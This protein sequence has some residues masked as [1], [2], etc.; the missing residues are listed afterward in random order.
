ML[1]RF[2]PFQLD[3]ANA[4]L[5]H[6]ETQL[7][8]RPKTFDLLVHLVR[9]AGELVTKDKLLTVVW[10]DI[11]VSE[12]TLT[13]SMSELRKVL[14][15]TARDPQ[16][17][18]TVHRR[19]Y[20]FIGTVTELQASDSVVETVSPHSSERHSIPPVPEMRPQAVVTD[21]SPCLVE[22]EA[23]LAQLHQQFEQALQGQRQFIFV[24]GEA[25]IGKTSLVDAFVAQLALMPSIWIGHGQCIEQYG[26]GEAY[27]PLLEAFGRLGR[28]PEGVQIVNVL[29]Q[30]APTWLIQLSALVSDSD[31]ESLNQ[32]A[33]G[34]TPA[35]ML[36][37]L[38]EAV[39]SLA[40]TRP[41]ILILEDLHWSDTSTLEW[42]AYTAR[43]RET[44]R[45][46]VVATYRPADA[47]AQGHPVRRVIQ[48]LL[49]HEHCLEMGLNYLSQRGIAAYLTLQ[50]DQVPRQRAW[51]QRLRQWT[52]GNPLFL[53]TMMDYL[54]KQGALNE[55]AN[56]WTGEH[57]EAYQVGIPESLH[58]MIE[59]QLE[60]A[61]DG[62][63]TLLE[64]A[65]V[66]GNEFAVAAVAA[67]LNHP[68]DVIESRCDSLAREGQFVQ[69]RGQDIWSDGTIATRYGFIHDLYREICYQRVPAGRQAQ[70][71]QHIGNRLEVGYG[72][73]AGDISAEL[74]AHFTRGHDASRAFH[75]WRLAGE[76]ALQRCAHQE[77]VTCFENALVLFP[78]LT[79]NHDYTEQ[80]IDL[81]L[82]LRH[83]FHALGDFKRA[84]A[85]LSDA[86][87]L[88]ES[89][90]DDYRLGWILSYMTVYFRVMGDHEQAIAT[91]QRTLALPVT[92]EDMA[93]RLETTLHLGPAYH[94]RGDYLQAIEMFTT[95]LD[96]LKRHPISDSLGHIGM[97][98]VA[99]R[100][101]P[102]WSLAEVGAFT[103][104]IQL[105]QEGIELAQTYDHPFSLAMAYCALGLLYLRKGEYQTCIDVLEHGMTLCQRHDLSSWLPGTMAQLGFAYTQ[106]GHLRK[107]R[108]L[109]EQALPESR[110]M[111]GGHPLWIAWLSDVM[112]RDEQLSEASVLAERSLTLARDRKEQGHTAW[113]LH[114]LGNVS[115]RLKPQAL[116][117]A[118]D[119]YHHALDLAQELSMRPLQAHCH[120]GL[121]T[122]YSRA[123]Q[124]EQA[125]DELSAAIQM[126]RD[127]EMGCD[128]SPARS[129]R[130]NDPL[131]IAGHERTQGWKIWLPG[132]KVGF[133]P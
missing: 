21:S 40:A 59:Q 120:R 51:V 9:H 108:R 113:A 22:R 106:S 80:A 86:L 28:A 42:L 109:L 44:A 38:A 11:V 54:F 84:Y 103:E 81:R 74:A 45:L 78:S 10:S 56:G 122:L 88:A 124:P 53:V 57:G 99:A 100:A 75:Y 43:R 49:R 37:E 35:R 41:L 13:A 96:M 82:A 18:V 123:G 70:W 48:E 126:Y 110:R 72:P 117:Q 33:R 58:H 107:G 29:R 67:A 97:T 39:E 26:A 2:G 93:L 104:G 94:A 76:T 91:G 17:I 125:H 83:A 55:G 65:S 27:L 121:G 60:Q 115:I 114:L 64:A 133:Q 102:L 116:S 66:A 89:L 118:H 4:A 16:F 98:A 52:N 20:R 62:V 23:D 69:R 8:L 79:E 73:C 3:F 34:A 15:E 36:R 130:M 30:Q 119:H 71:H 32:R 61:P 111:T 87:P 25:G 47:I 1:Y 95:T 129:W 132:V 105:G 12:S 128:R 7:T 46:M 6:G 92:Q 127:M 63:V 90:Q 5:W 68:L 85:T 131:S 112:L 77:T 50:Y 14:G 24:T 19:G 31:L 101:Y